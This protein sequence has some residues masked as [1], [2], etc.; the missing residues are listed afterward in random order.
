M[1]VFPQSHSAHQAHYAQRIVPSTRLADQATQACLF[2]AVA[3]VLSI[4]SDSLQHAW[5]QAASTIRSALGADL[6][7]LLLHEAR[8]GDLVAIGRPTSALGH[9]QRAAGLDQRPLA[10][11]SLVA[12]VF[13]TGRANLEPAERKDIV[14]RFAIASLMLCRVQLGRDVRGVRQA[15]SCQPDRFTETD[16]RFLELAARCISLIGQTAVPAEPPVPGLGE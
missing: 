3:A 9:Q 1:A 7:D 15:G 4:K 8:A 13:Q 10:A 6:V 5:S 2:T 11:G 12:R 16:L 14:E